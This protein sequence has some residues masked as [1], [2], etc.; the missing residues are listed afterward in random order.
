MT[1]R[2][3]WRLASGAVLVA[4]AAGACTGGYVED[5]A[6][7]CVDEPS[8]SRCRG[9]AGVGGAGGSS[10]QGGS[11]MQG[12]GGNGGM[13][14][15]G[16][17]GAGGAG[18]LRCEAP[19][20]ECKGVCVDV[21]A[22]DAQNC[23]EC[24]YACGTGSSC[25]AGVCSAVAVVAGAL[26]P[27]A[28]AVDDDNVYFVS[29]VKD[30][31][32]DL[33]FVSKAPRG[34]GGP[35]ESVFAG[36]PTF[37]SRSLSLADGVLY[38]GVLDN[39]GKIFKGP[40]DGTGFGQ[41]V[42]GDQPTVQCLSAADGRLWWSAFNGG[43]SFVRRAPQAGDGVAAQ[44]LTFQAGR[45]DALVVDGVGAT[46]VAYWVNR[47]EN[48]TQKGGLWRKGE[49]STEV[50]LVASEQMIQLAAGA[51]AMFIADAGQGI[52]RTGKVFEPGAEPQNVVPSAMIGGTLQGLALVGDKLYWLA[53]SGSNLELHRSGLDGSGAR[54]LGG[55]AVKSP[56]YWA[57]PF[58]ASAIV[59]RDGSVY[60]ADPGSVVGLDPGD[61]NYIGA[62]ASPDGA[63]YRLPEGPGG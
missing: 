12:G 54:V 13:P 48:P 63:I 10:G 44:E 17:S 41:H 7:Y 53:L 15:M 30:T 60:F 36:N 24:G 4:A 8:D 29:P 61:I 46:A 59:V 35:I 42:T 16:S 43:N 62:S 55:V 52:L 33:P 39:S 38:F 31:N 45:V 27:Y 57:S 50:R 18:G 23:G 32:G 6:G 14:S 19:A 47:D 26:S 2:T 37:R 25:S 20:V 3:L 49:A 58:G 22:S 5:P 51:E 28:F 40:V 21:K 9:G 11:T 1:L 34:G 56:A